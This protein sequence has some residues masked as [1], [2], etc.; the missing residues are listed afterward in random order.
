MS[1][2]WIT[3]EERFPRWARKGKDTAWAQTWRY[4]KVWYVWRNSLSSTRDWRTCS[5]NQGLGTQVQSLFWV[6]TQPPQ[7]VFG[8]S[9]DGGWGHVWWSLSPS[10]PFPLMPVFLFGQ[11]GL[12]KSQNV[13]IHMSW[14]SRIEAETSPKKKPGWQLAASW[15]S[16][17]RGNFDLEPW[18]GLG[19]GYQLSLGPSRGVLR[20]LDF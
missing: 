2:G 18:W 12:A 7:L 10:H 8:S 11:R 1:V 17:T 13:C 5:L 15:K 6:S 3:L 4:G 9:Q 19:G 20:K 16:K 14:V